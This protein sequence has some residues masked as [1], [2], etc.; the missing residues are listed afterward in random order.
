MKCIIDK[1][2]MVKSA[3][4]HIQLVVHMS[5]CFV[6]RARSEERCRRGEKKNRVTETLAQSVVLK[7]RAIILESRAKSSAEVNRRQSANYQ[8]IICRVS[9]KISR[10]YSKNSIFFFLLCIFTRKLQM[11]KKRLK[12]SG[13]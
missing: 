3:F 9:R 7:Q 1:Q 2:E 4:C 10:I 11:K 13:S 12:K 5:I 8:W 6:D